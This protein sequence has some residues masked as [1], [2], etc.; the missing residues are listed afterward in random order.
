MGKGFY[1]GMKVT[2]N[3]EY[4]VVI[5]RT[6]DADWDKEPGIIRWDSNKQNDEEDWRGLYGSFVDSGG[7]EID[8]THQFQFINENGELREHQ[9]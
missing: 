5:E 7:K 8:S 2:L 6:R 4:G 1:I 9:N 3:N